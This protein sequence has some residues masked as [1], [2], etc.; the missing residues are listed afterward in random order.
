MSMPCFEI[1]KCKLANYTNDVNKD[2]SLIKGD[3]IV[4]LSFNEDD[5]CFDKSSNESIYYMSN[6]TYNCAQEAGNG[7]VTDVS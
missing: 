4:K 5:G 1:G 6:L 2:L 7:I 3:E